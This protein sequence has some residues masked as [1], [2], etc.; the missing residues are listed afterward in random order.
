M[1]SCLLSRFSQGPNKRVP[2]G[3]LYVFVNTVSAAVFVTGSNVT[4]RIDSP[5]LIVVF[6]NVKS[7]PSSRHWPV[8]LHR[9]TFVLEGL[10]IS[11]YSSFTLLLGN[12]ALVTGL[13]MTSLI[14]TR[15]PGAS[16]GATVVAG[17][18]RQWLSASG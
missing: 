2:A 13:Y 3:R 4:T 6:V 15:M 5:A 1:R 14:R 9:S 10:N 11:M 16:F 12:I 17:S 18:V 8:A 7:I